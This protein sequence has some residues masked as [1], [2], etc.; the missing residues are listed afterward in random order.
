MPTTPKPKS[1]RS[2]SKVQRTGRSEELVNL[3]H[4]LHLRIDAPDWET[5]MGRSDLVSGDG[6]AKGCQEEGEGEDTA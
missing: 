2:L 1:G 5:Q 3:G 6:H 4:A